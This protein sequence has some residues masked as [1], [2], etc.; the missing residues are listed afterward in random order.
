[1]K[2]T[3]YTP[4]DFGVANSTLIVFFL[5]NFFVSPVEN[6]IGTHKLSEWTPHKP[7]V[8]NEGVC[9]I[10]IDLAYGSHWAIFYSYKFGL[11]PCIL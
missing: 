1:M 9:S 5:S 11:V 7:Y 4:D 10:F 8:T 2:H 3:S 6:P